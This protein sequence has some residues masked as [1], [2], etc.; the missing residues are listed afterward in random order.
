[1]SS[2]DPSI[3][4][5]AAA[6]NKRGIELARGGRWPDALAHFDRAVAL[7]PDYAE[8]YNNRALIL[9]E[10]NRPADALASLDRGVALTPD[11]A[12]AHNNRG[13]V[14]QDLKRFD[15]ALAAH[16]Q[17]LALKPDFAEAQFNTATA[18]RALKRFDE[19]IAAFEKALAL[20]PDYPEA[21]QNLGVT[22]QDEKRLEEAVAAYRKAI[23]LRPHY[24]EAYNNLGF[25]E[26]QLGRFTDG[27][28]D[29]E[30]R[31]QLPGAPA[32]FFTR[33]EWRGEAL[34]GK[35]LLV[36][37]EQG[38]GDTLQ[39]CVY[40]KAAA[41]RGIKTVMAVQDPLR[42]LLQ[43]LR[44]AVDIVGPDAMLA[45]Y[46]YHCSLMSLPGRLGVTLDALPAER[47]YIAAD[48]ALSRLWN[49]RLPPRPVS[50]KPR[51]GVAWSGNPK[52]KND[53]NR[54]MT[55]QALSPIFAADAHW[56]ALQKDV[57]AGDAALLAELPVAP[58]GGS[59]TDF[60]DT[61]ALI[62]N[63]D[64]VITVDTSVAHLA[65]AMG[66]PV[67]ILLA[68][69]PDWRWFLEGE[70]SPWYPSA[71]LFRQDRSRSWENAVARLRGAV[72]EFARSRP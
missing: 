29:Y 3:P 63:L 7:K 19:A 8:A 17:A 23:A 30:W 61:A 59:L 58:L 48:P 6:H 35:T 4:D 53:H 26:L 57:R 37:A 54:S 66:K 67:W 49:D 36:H 28:R 15:E 18:L 71:R 2:P 31:K 25:C 16:A 21:Y 11:N 50:P 44:P 20:R 65:G 34:A 62:D 60:A 52:Q 43:Q 46:D 45:A 41:A 38:F 68:Y 27:F 24:A 1:M 56:I 9:Q 5:D 51:I 40:G 13:A 22:L 72:H 10:L 14:L 12:R 42:R 64:L 47:N 55:L 32:Q 33:P 39:F 69:Y 70:T